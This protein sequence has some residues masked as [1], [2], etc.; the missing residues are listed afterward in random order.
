MGYYDDERNVEEYIKMAEGYDGRHLIDALKA[1]LAAGATVLEL[2]MGPGKDLDML[3]QIYRVTG[4]DNSAVFLE[5]YRRAHPDTDLIRLDAASLA[6]DRQFDGIYSNKTLQ[7]L[8]RVECRRSLQRQVQVL[9]PGGIALHGL[10]YGEG[11]ECY[12]GLRS[13]YYTEDAIKAI[14]P[15]DFRLLD[16]F[17]YKEAE[18]G[19]SICLVLQRRPEHGD[20]DE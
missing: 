6:T 17:R 20:D 15:A 8:S 9:K 1:Y 16:I 18:E 19:D 5:R 7:H 14:L 10:W 3:K 4:S 2:G 13:V 12:D 11:E